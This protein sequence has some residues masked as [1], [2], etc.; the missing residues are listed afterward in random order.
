[1]HKSHHG[2]FNCLVADHEVTERNIDAKDIKKTNTYQKDDTQHVPSQSQY[3]SKRHINQQSINNRCRSRGRQQLQKNDILDSAEITAISYVGYV[4]NKKPTKHFITN[5]HSHI[6]DVL[7]MRTN[8][9]RTVSSELSNAN[10]KKNMLLR[11]NQTTTIIHRQL[12]GS[13]L[14]DQK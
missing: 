9:A 7:N 10:H 14:E 8:G 3:C 13:G 4:I 12:T 11:R 1:M 5:H 2:R 6:Q